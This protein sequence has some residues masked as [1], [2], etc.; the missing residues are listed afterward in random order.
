M[1]EYLRA[2]VWYP[3][4]EGL[5]VRPTS[6]AIVCVL[7]CGAGPDALKELL[8]TEE[9][10]P[11]PGAKVEPG[12]RLV[13][14]KD[15]TPAGITEEHLD[16]LRKH[17]SAGDKI[18]I[19]RLL[20][21]GGAI[22]LPKGTDVLVLRNLRPAPA[23][24]RLRS[25]LSGD[26]VRRRLQ[27]A[28]LNQSADRT[29]YPVEVRI[30]GGPLKDKAMFVPESSIAPLKTLERPRTFTHRFGGKKGSRYEAFRRPAVNP[31][32]DDPSSMA[33]AML[34]AGERAERKGNLQ[35]AVGAYWFTMTEHSDLPQAAV[36]A[37]RLK[38]MGFSRVGTRDYELD[39]AKRA[40]PKAA[41]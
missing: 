6:L 36:A 22:K 38:A 32:S 18:G 14:T 2:C 1:V 24:P 5:I 3:D 11:D 23:P 25:G 35:D 37:E 41:K 13:V 7:V 20:K 39:F 15:E 17:L 33:A 34:E 10:V 30:Q 31:G 29:D 40:K 26:Q 19:D 4:A 8:P 16:Y 9:Q 28:A 21:D 12:H 27:D